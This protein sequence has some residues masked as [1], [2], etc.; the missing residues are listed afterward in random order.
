MSKETREVLLTDN[1]DEGEEHY[2][3]V[4]DNY[5]QYCKYE[6]KAGRKSDREL[7]RLKWNGQRFAARKKI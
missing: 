1:E 6:D 2:D 5:S 7:S 3:V 4:D